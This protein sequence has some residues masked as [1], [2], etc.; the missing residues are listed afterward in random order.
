MIKNNN[1][2][3]PNILQL[4]KYA[5]SGNEDDLVNLASTLF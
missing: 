1:I 2:Q 3:D 5:E 4:V